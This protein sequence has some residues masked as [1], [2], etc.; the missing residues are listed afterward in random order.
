M[1]KINVTYDTIVYSVIVPVYNNSKIIKKF[2]ISNKCLFHKNIEVIFVDDKST[3]NTLSILNTFIN[4]ASF[5]NFRLFSLKKNNGPGKA[6]NYGLKKS[7]GKYV[8]FLDSDDK[9]F[10]KNFNLLL[11]KIK[12]INNLDLIIYNFKKEKNL[13]PINLFNINNSKKKIIKKFLRTELDMSPN[14]YLFNKIFLLKKKIFF[15]KG[16]YEDILFLLKVFVFMKNWKKFNII[17]YL[18]KNNIKSITNTFSDKHL[19]S[20]LRSCSEKYLFVK[21][22]INIKYKNYNKHLQYGLRGDYIFANKIFTKIKKSKYSK[23]FI[24]KFFL[25]LL[26]KQFKV[27]T[28]YDLRVKEELFSG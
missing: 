14:Y 21:R 24:K 10:N 6:R 25:K 23:K 1:K 27:I 2:F 11:K 12:R 7:K 17:V 4:K 22:Q 9:I 28:N 8:M 5:K 20:F 16:Y 19:I 18:K 13:M 3:D 15:E 26:D